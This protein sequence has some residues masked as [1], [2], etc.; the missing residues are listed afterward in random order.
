MSPTNPPNPAQ[1]TKPTGDRRDELER[2]KAQMW[3]PDE[4]EELRQERIRKALEALR[5]LPK[6]DVD[7]QVLKEIVEDPDIEY[8]EK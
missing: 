5:S 8:Y 7:P 2:I 3:P 6:W 4:P 1:Q